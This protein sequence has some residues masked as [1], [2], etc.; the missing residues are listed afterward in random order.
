MAVEPFR[1]R[2]RMRVCAECG[3]IT[4][5]LLRG[6]DLALRFERRRRRAGIADQGTNIDIR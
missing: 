5:A 2:T 3:E 4:T 6:A 1:L